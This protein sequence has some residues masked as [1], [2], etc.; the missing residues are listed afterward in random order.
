M[1]NKL[2]NRTLVARLAAGVAALVL[3]QSVL[4]QNSVV[5]DAADD[6]LPSKGY[7]DI[8]ASKIEASSDARVRRLNAGGVFRDYGKNFV[9]K[10]C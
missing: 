1:N 3:S 4:A 2:N 9:A 5:P 10:M 7:L 6:A 8:L